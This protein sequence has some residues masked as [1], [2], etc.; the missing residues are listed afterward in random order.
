VKA[1]FRISEEDY[2]D[3]MDLFAKL[4]L[5]MAV[6]F[7]IS[8]LGLVLV[9]LFGSPIF[10]SGA[11]GG[12]VGGLA[13]TLIARYIVSPRLARRHYRN[14][15][16]IQE[17]FS[18]ELLE[19]GIRY[20]SPNAEGKT[21]WSQV[22][23]WRQNDKYVLIYL[24]PRLFQIVPKSIAAQGFDCQALTNRLLQHVGKPG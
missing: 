14:Y 19:D 8:A 13:V 5:R 1:T 15:K 3:A 24:M 10:R 12:L 9:A 20:V 21:I 6:I 22:H 4:T 16:A 17:E 18:L 11:I 2:V 7:P 23:K